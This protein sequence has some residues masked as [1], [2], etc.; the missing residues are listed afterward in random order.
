MVVGDIL[1]HDN[2]SEDSTYHTYRHVHITT[3]SLC[4]KIVVLLVL[5]GSSIFCPKVGISS[6][7]DQLLGAI[8]CSHAC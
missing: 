7:P 4:A 8:A 3:H 6:F 5:T 1:Y 2:I